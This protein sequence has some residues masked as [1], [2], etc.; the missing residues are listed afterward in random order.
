MLLLARVA[1]DER[2]DL[3]KELSV[4][5]YANRKYTEQSRNFSEH[6]LLNIFED[7]AK[8]DIDSKLG[9]IDLKIGMEKIFMSV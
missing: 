1:M 9:K 8:L 4:N 6:E 3:V 2:K 5:S 7:L